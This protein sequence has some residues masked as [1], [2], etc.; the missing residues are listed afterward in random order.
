[1]PTLELLN[2]IGMSNN[3]L[4]FRFA[5]IKRKMSDENHFIVYFI[6]T[7]NK[8]RIIVPLYS[9][10]HHNGPRAEIFLLG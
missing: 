10:E 9:A 5:L 3:F 2:M 8:L 7:A 6:L 1:M 4:D